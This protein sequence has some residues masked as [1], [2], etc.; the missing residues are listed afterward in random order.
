MEIAILNQGLAP[1]LIS[2]FLYF[3]LD[4]SE[5][6][7]K[8][9]VNF[10]ILQG[11]HVFAYVIY[12]FKP[13]KVGGHNWIVLLSMIIMF[14]IVPIAGLIRYFSFSYDETDNEYLHSWFFTSMLIG[15]I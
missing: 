5:I 10:I 15:L 12:S 14:V 9:L 11:I 13:I 6:E 4:I 3:L 2:W 1:F 8:I 7:R